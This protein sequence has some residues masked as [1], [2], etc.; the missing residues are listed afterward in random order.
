MSMEAEYA[1]TGD[2]ALR[3]ALDRKWTST[4][5]IWA[6]EDFEKKRPQFEAIRKEATETI[7]A[8]A[9][10]LDRER[11]LN[12][13]W[14]LLL[15][16]ATANEMHHKMPPALLHAIDVYHRNL[17]DQPVLLSAWKHMAKQT[18][19]LNAIRRDLGGSV[20]ETEPEPPTTYRS[21]ADQNRNEG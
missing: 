7:N 4:M 16:E 17:P 10:G 12:D 5:R 1:A 19:L 3:R 2:P 11:F 21:A 8:K 20:Y 13:L 14:D 15:A 6:A 9:A 18:R